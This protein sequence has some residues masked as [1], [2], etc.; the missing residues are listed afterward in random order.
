[1]EFEEIIKK[2]EWLDDQQ[3]KDKTELGELSSLLASLDNN[4]KALAQQLRGL[5]QQVNDISIAAARMEQFDKMLAKH[6][7]DTTKHVETVEK[8]LTRR[9]LEAGKLR[10]AETDELRKTIFELRAAVGAE[11]T[12]RKDKALEDQRRAATLQD[13]GTAIEA[14]VRSTKEVQ[15][16]NKRLDETRR[17]DAKSLNDLQAEVAALRK[18]AEE[19]RQKDALHNDSIRNLENRLNE[20]IQ[21]ETDRQERH[22]A[23]LQEQALQQVERDRAWKDWQEKYEQFRQQVGGA[24]SQ[25]AAFEESIRAVKRAQDAYDGLSQ[26]LERRIAETG[27]IQRLSDE[28][29]RQEWVAFKADEQKR[30]TGHTLAQEESIRELRKDVD[31]IESRVT[32]LDD[33]AQTMQDQLQQTTD[34]TE[35][36]LQELM[37]LSQDWLSAYERIMGHAKT[38]AQKAVR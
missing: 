26:R 5:T 1:M 29:T 31:K 14:A 2:V 18:R 15:E 9:D 23:L 22:A 35:K 6:R 32:A 20:L 28:R 24:Q 38:K 13:L 37:N 17:H 21:T 27:E 8:N 10:G 34:V 4:I 19:A 7:T 25:A 33:A 11:Q 36:Q 16:A 30:W 3:R 12:A